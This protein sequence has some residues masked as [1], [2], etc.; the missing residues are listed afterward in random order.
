MGGLRGTAVEIACSG[1]PQIVVWAAPLGVCGTWPWTSP[2]PVHVL[3]AW[4]P[5]DARLGEDENRARQAALE[6]ELDRL[7]PRDLW[8]ARGV[9]PVSGHCDEGVA[10]RGLTEGVLR[11]AGARYDQ[12]AIFRWT[13]TEWAIVACAGPRRVVQGWSL[14]EDAPPERRG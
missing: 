10:V 7:H 13:P 11:E 6:A 9:D 14:A 2:D 5:R 12:D 4:D 1:E 3:T 8:P